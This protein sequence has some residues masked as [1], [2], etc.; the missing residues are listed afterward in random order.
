[1]PNGIVRLHRFGAALV[2]S[3]LLSA[4]SAAPGVAAEPSSVSAAAT[5]VVAW[6]GN[7]DW[8]E[9]TVPAEAQSGVDAIAGG[10]STVWP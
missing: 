7:N 2:M 5:S 10:T 3:G 9:A 8:G 1:M 4:L 6:G